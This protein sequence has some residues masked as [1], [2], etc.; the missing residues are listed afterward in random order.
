V[1]KAEVK[2]FDQTIAVDWFQFWI[3]SSPKTDLRRSKYTCEVE[4]AM[5]M[6]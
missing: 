6:V 4:P 3:N 1:D 2:N 5:P